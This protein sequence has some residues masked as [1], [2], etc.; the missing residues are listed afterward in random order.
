MIHV[1]WDVYFLSLLS[2]GPSL[3]LHVPPPERPVFTSDIS[4][5]L[6]KLLTGHTVSLFSRILGS[7]PTY[8][9]EHDSVVGHRPVDEAF[10]EKLGPV[11]TEEAISVLWTNV[12]TNSRNDLPTTIPRDILGNSWLLLR[13]RSLYERI[14]AGAALWFPQETWCSYAC[15]C[16][17]AEVPF[18]LRAEITRAVGTLLK[19]HN[20]MWR[21]SFE[22]QNS[23]EAVLTDARNNQYPW[24][25]VETWL[26]HI[27]SW[28]NTATLS[29]EDGDFITDILQH[30]N[31]YSIWEHLKEYYRGHGLNFYHKSKSNAKG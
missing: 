2:G 7:D 27:R 12:L 3:Y 1:R 14:N 24:S 30:N 23:L 4:N 22:D 19:R 17:E 31:T 8:F 15:S 26:T 16:Y 25:E 6:Q 20:E 11:W 9:L 5:L 28:H 18:Y 21:T 29:Y 13:W 10:W